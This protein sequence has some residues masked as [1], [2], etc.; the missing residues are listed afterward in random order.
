MIHPERLVADQLVVFVAHRKVARVCLGPALSRAVGRDNDNG[1]LRMDE[2]EFL[3]QRT[4]KVSSGV[5]CCTAGEFSC[6]L[7]I[8]I[9]YEIENVS[10]RYAQRTKTK[11]MF[12]LRPPHG[13]IDL[14]YFEVS[15]WKACVNP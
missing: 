9:A 2:C 4:D 8:R 7:G 3:I 13:E 15:A 10:E 6:H 11:A 14:S 12:H 5:V 1:M